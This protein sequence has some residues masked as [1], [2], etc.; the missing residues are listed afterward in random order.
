ML[1]P[2]TPEEATKRMRRDSESVV[3]PINSFCMQFGL[4]HEDVMQ[5]LRA[6]RLGAEGIPDGNGGY[7]DLIISAKSY[8]TWIVDPETPTK[9]KR[10]VSAFTKPQPR[11]KS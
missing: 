2:L 6:G 10:K 11:D 7:Y 5:E 4:S 3:F 9:L 8:L 1:E